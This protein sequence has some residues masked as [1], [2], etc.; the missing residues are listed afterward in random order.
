MTFMACAHFDFLYQ[1]LASDRIALV[2]VAV[3]IVADLASVLALGECLEQLGRLNLAN[4][5]C[6]PWFIR[7]GSGSTVSVET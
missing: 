4:M 1:L 6:H 7:V 2:R 3:A 5:L